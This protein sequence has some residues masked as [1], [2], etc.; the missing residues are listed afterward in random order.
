MA[1]TNTTIDTIQDIRTSAS[2]TFA[3]LTLTNATVIGSN[4]VVFQ[5]ATDSTTFLQVLNADGN[6]TFNINTTSRNTTVTGNLGTELITNGGFDTDSDWDKEAGWT[7]SGD[8]AHDTG[9]ARLMQN[10]SVTNGKT[11]KVTYEIIAHT[12]GSIFVQLGGATGGTVAT[13][14]SSIGTF[15]ETIVAGPSTA[16]IQFDSVGAAFI[17]SIDNVSVREVLTTLTADGNFIAEGN[18]TYKG[19][20]FL[21]KDG[22]HSLFSNTEDLKITNEGD[23]ITQ[24]QFLIEN[25]SGIMHKRNHWN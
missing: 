1:I 12:S 11:Y 19:K 14:R 2:P 21:D 24:R 5:P 6:S 18:V 7:I 23:V 15:T 22:S 4:S 13:A 10:I 25:Y 8:A 9:T 20:V 16:R 17:G 3:G